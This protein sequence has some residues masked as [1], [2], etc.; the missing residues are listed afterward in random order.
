MQ[1]KTGIIYLQRDKFQVYSPYLSNILEFNFVPELI[2]NFDIVN[3]ELFENLL[4]AFFINN[5][6]PAGNFI[7]VISEN[8]SFIKDFTNL[9]PAAQ[10]SPQPVSGQNVPVPPT[11]E[12]LQTQANEFIEHVPFE[13][14]AG[15]TYP[16][17]NGVRAFGTNQ[18]MFEVIKITLE[19][20]GFIVSFVIPGF[21]FGTE[22][23]SINSLNVNV[24][25]T[26][27]QKINLFKEYNLISNQR[28][29][30]E[31]FVTSEANEKEE[32]SEEDNF[33]EKK[34]GNKPIFLIVLISVIIIIILGTIGILIWQFSTPAYKPPSQP[35][36]QTPVS[37]IAPQATIVQVSPVI[38]GVKDLTV[39]IV[40]SSSSP[41][42]AE[43]IKTMFLSYGFSNLDIEVRDSLQASQ[44]SIIFSSRVNDEIKNSII[45]GARK[46]LGEILVQNKTDAV[47]DV[48]IILGK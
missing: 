47:V 18:E 36:V 2:R 28:S 34:T 25:N 20:Q 5:K 37:S 40:T 43:S 22:L 30:F 8:A 21:V 1:T 32:V 14:V 19:K 6:I 48:S 35:V 4:K 46:I 12:D 41:G 10:N 16:L 11:L 27:L 33:H 26:I 39:Q 44:S 3:K 31:T 29:T 45:T 15:K 9:L 24:I 7:I 23:G 42:L 13:D 38:T 17:P